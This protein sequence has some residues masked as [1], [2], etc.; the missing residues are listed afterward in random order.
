MWTNKNQI[1]QIEDRVFLVWKELGQTPLQE[2]QRVRKQL[3]L[4]DKVKMTY[5]GRLD[6][7]AEGELLILVGEACKRKE[8]FLKLDKTYQFKVLVGF[9]TDTLDLLGLI[10]QFGS[11]TS[12]KIKNHKNLEVRLPN[13]VERLI[14]GHTWPYPAYSAR[15][16]DGKPLW[17]WARE[18]KYKKL[19][20]DELVPLN[21]F[22][23]KDLNY[24]DAKQIE[25]RELLQYIEMLTSKVSGDFRQAEILK[26][27]QKAVSSGQHKRYLLLEFST[28]LSSGGYVR[29]LTGEIGKILNVH[30]TTFS[31]IRTKIIL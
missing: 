18:A 8:E 7:A 22:E 1:K 16:V 27:W 20:K 28:T 30:T 3:G 5:A 13:I 14:G 9:E 21:N 26:S 4:D 29:Q 15:P 23:I 24:L 17:Q 31:I 19:L 10:T 6:P 11:P 25:V 12:K 2:L